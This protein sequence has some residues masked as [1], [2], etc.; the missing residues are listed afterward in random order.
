MVGSTNIE[1][2]KSASLSFWALGCAAKLVKRHK[3]N[4]K[5]LAQTLSDFPSSGSSAEK[6]KNAHH[7]YVSRPA[8]TVFS[9]WQLGSIQKRVKLVHVNT[10]SHSTV[11]NKVI[12][13]CLS[14]N[15]VIA[16]P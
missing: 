9:S 11:A 2:L 16:G 15:K 12:F 5:V 7:T 14:L 6:R 1:S 13:S 3:G 8:L 4:G 10:E